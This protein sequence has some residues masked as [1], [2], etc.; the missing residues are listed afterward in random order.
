LKAGKTLEQ[1]SREL[2]RQN[3]TK[4]DYLA[5]AYAISAREG[6][7]GDISLSL[8][9]AGDNVFGV[10]KHAHAQLAGLTGIPKPYYDKMRGVSSALLSVNIN[11]WL[12]M[13]SDVHTVRTM[14]G[15]ARAFLSDKYR[16]LDNYD[17]A[18][19]LLPALEKSQA[20]IESCDITETKFYLKAVR[21]ASEGMEV[22]VGDVVKSGIVI[23]NSEVGAGSLRIEPLVYRLSC[24][25]GAIAGTKMRKYH[26]GRRADIDG[27]S[28]KYLSE[29]TR[30]LDD[31]A[32]W[33][34][35]RDL[36]K[37]ALDDAIL[38]DWVEL[39]RESQRDRF[40]LP[41]AVTSVVSKDYG[42]SDSEGHGVLEHLAAG[43]DMTRYGL[44]NAI[45]RFSQD[46]EDY[47]RATELERIGGQVF[48]MSREDWEM[49]AHRAERVE[50]KSSTL[51]GVVGR[52]RK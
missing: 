48:E 32:F 47:D 6:A 9:S 39:A 1:L 22:S 29:D 15:N 37:A 2:I 36:C 51:A 34:K 12:R 27:D 7:D 40:E 30:R 31:R 19:A 44:V 14:D 42:L 16:P 45:T 18:S 28:I 41:V 20:V 49:I 21:H 23:S 3:E 11:A 25:N 13:S 33:M 26:A 8:G 24:L 4:A 17:L 46:T 52:R 5:T 38:A 10:T 43:G 35:V 50:G